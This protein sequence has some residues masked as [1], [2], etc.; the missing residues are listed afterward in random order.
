MVLRR[1]NYII[2]RRK[3]SLICRTCTSDCQ[4]PS[5]QIPEDKLEQ[6]ADDYGRK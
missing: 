1:Y 5:D 3:T 4:T 2:G 6:G